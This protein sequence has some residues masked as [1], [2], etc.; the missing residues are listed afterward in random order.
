MAALR[1]RPAL[2]DPV[3]VTGAG[4][5]LG[6][7]VVEHLVASGTSTRALTRCPAPW[8][9]TPTTEVDL[10]ADIDA[11][12]PTLEGAAAVVHLAGTNEAQAR[13]DPER[14]LTSTILAARRVADACLAAGVKRVVY[15]STVHVYGAA[16]MPG[17]T[18]TEATVPEPRA[19]YAIARLAAEHVLAGAGIDT[20]VLRLTNGVGAPTAPQVDRWSLVVND[21]C[22][23]AVA[24]GELRLHTDG[25]QHRD[26]VA[27][28]DVCRVVAAAADPARVPAGTYNLG[29]GRPRTVRAVAE[30][31]QRAV[32][33]T[34][35]TRPP[36]HAPVPGRAPSAS[37]TVDAGRLAALGLRAEIPLD[38]AIDE[39]VRFCIE[40]RDYLTA[41]PLA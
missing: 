32:E 10:A 5:Y 26:F 18:I 7:R 28:A 15:V 17:S 25:L 8:L 39:T 40:H 30:A 23:Q 12:V 11:L 9:A 34:T 35:G 38:A 27:L 29:S 16:L 2:S 31:V 4:G 1:D 14:A 13:D 24:T 19:G 20:V 21:L 6:G 33:R 36:L 37:F 22:R 3:V 41:S